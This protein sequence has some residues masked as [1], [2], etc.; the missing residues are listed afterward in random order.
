MVEES[1]ESNVSPFPIETR[2]RGVRRDAAVERDVESWAAKLATSFDGIMRADVVVEEPHRHH[3][4]GRRYKVRINLSL[5]GETI[6][7]SREPGAEGAHE[8]PHVAVRDAFLAARRRLEDWVHKD[9]RHF[10]KRHQPSHGRIAYLD[11]QGDWGFLEAPDGHRVYFH[12]NAVVGLGPGLALGD[13]VRFT[14][15]MGDQGPQ[16]SSVIPL[17]ANAHHELPRP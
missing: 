10:E 11:V 1:L 7:I 12:R 9:L 16:A 4:N 6:A 2:F 17:G 5:P 13:E 8:D 3:R 15:E 14:E